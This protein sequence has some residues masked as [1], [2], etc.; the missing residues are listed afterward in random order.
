MSAVSKD[1]IKK[2][3][4]MSP[5]FPRADRPE[6]WRSAFQSLIRQF[7]LLESAKTPCG[8]P[9]PISEAHALMELLRQPDLT[10]NNLADMLGLTKSTVSRLVERLERLG[11]LSRR[12]DNCD[13]RARRLR[14]TA[15]GERLAREINGRSLRRF[16][17]LLD[18]I[19]RTRRIAVLESLELLHKATPQPPY[20][21]THV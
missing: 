13:R 16:A 14:L 9:M 11:Q 17:A 15:K 12:D 8:K 4:R 21:K 5:H 18:G 7:G 20:K 3:N 19:P 6:T 2:E 10:Q 1:N